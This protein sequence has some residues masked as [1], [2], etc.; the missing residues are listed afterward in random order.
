V[1]VIR[2]MAKL[3]HTLSYLYNLLNTDKLHKHSECTYPLIIKTS[4]AANVTDVL[5]YTKVKT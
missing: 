5:A 4:H 1:L 3:I 2:S